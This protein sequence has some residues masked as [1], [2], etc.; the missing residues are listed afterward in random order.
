MSQTRPAHWERLD[1]DAQRAAEGIAQTLTTPVRELGVEA[2]RE[3]WAT[4]PA[5]S[6]ITF[7]DRVENLVL[8][9]RA[10][11]V[12]ARF[13]HPPGRD[14]P[15]A[16]PLLLYLHGGGFVLGTLEGADEVC[17]A[18]A[19]K[20][21]WAVIS[22][23]YRLAPENPY[24]AALED[25][26]DAFMWIQQSAMD[27]GIDPE[28]IAVGGDSAGG[29]LAAALCLQLRDLGL[30]RPVSQ[31]LVYPVVD[32]DFATPSWAEFGD[33]PALTTEDAKWFWS[34]YLGPEHTGSVEAYAAPMNASSLHDLPPALMVTAEIDALRDDA[35]AY[36]E[37]L[38]EDG[39]S[40]TAI[41]YPG[42]FH[43][44]FTEL[45]ALAKADEAIEAVVDHLSALKLP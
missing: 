42:V 40:V 9:T 21:D 22:L 26:L 8:P 45:G 31:I 28:A 5:Q 10:G 43:G 41:R 14:V 25:C 37:R 32:D 44:F 12:R 13:Y 36:A 7:L 2:A 23:E 1:P 34:Q 3:L 29:N 17:R 6:P 30:A 19:A 27:L 18:I 24:P 15:D 20:S 33:G 39:V 4:P 16:R 11:Q 35:E 38:R